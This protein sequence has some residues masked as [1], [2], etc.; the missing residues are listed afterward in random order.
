MNYKSH[1]ETIY[2][3]R[4][5]TEVGWYK[6]HLRTSLELILRSGVS[7][8]GH[9][10]DVGGGVYSTPVVLKAL[11]A[12]GIDFTE[13]ELVQLEGKIHKAKFEFWE[14]TCYL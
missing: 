7:P 11:K 12:A 3:K 6:P 4:A 2:T 10:I 5:P 14:G 13:G 8:E 1:W 9:I